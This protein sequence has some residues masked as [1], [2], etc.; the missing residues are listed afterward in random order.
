MRRM[1]K[2]LN[3]VLL[4]FFTSFICLSN[5]KAANTITCEYE[6]N[7]DDHA[8]AIAADA[9]PRGTTLVIVFEA[10]GDHSEVVNIWEKTALSSGELLEEK[11][12]DSFDVQFELEETDDCPKSIYVDTFS[13]TITKTVE[14]MGNYNAKGETDRKPNGP[15]NCIN[16]D[17]EDSCKKSLADGDIACVWNKDY[18]ICNVNNLTYVQ[19]G[20]SYRI[21][22]EI[23]YMTG[24]AVT[25]LKTFTPIILILIGIITLVKSLPQGEDDVN[26]A[27]KQLVKKIIAGVMV[28][29]IISIVQFV[30]LK[31]TEGDEKD[32]IGICLKC[33]LNNECGDVTYVEDGYGNCY[34]A[35]TKGDYEC[36]D[37]S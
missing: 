15:S 24:T 10:N 1:V 23:P 11:G 19:C 6:Y 28:F 34:N 25:I 18:G 31:A 30:M 21:P 8:Y 36:P 33:F 4:V 7:Y 26:K 29:L 32:S 17:T 27:R 3:L 35:F 9:L 12:K 22:S 37:N 13:K 14:G 20:N 5:V 16:Y 2:Y